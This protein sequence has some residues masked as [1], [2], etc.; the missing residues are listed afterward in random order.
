MPSLRLLVLECPL[1]T[2]SLKST[3]KHFSSLTIDL[4]LQVTKTNS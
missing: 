4:T 2:R 1:T 3:A